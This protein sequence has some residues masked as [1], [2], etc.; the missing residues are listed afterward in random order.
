MSNGGI[1]YQGPSMI[2]GSPVVA[3]ATGLADKSNNVKTGGMVQIWIIRSDMSPV[4]AANAGA[5]D[6]ICGNCVHRGKV[7][8]GKNVDRSC[9]VLLFQAPTNIYK[10][11]CRGA[12]PNIDNL[13]DT[14]EGRRVRLGAY[15]D[16][17]AVPE[18]VWY[19]VI[20]KCAGHTG[21]THQWRDFPG[22]AGI[23]MASVDT[24]PE[25]YEAQDMGFRTF[26][27][28]TDVDTLIKG[29]EFVCPASDEK[30]KVVSCSEC[31]ACGGNASPNKASVVIQVH[32]A[33]GK[34]EKFTKAVGG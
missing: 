11:F 30:G 31:L 4:D 27:V 3:I 7:V 6:S 22:L 19:D 8:N 17:A 2:D 21:Y 28:T 33:G 13:S 29:A 20:K 15:G 5:D 1:I 26:R 12:Y 24:L 9:Y 25:Y 23:C 34:K 32:G 10:T 14:F 18:S 16:P